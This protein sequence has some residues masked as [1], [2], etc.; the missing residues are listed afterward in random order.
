MRHK[1]KRL[2]RRQRERRRRCAAGQTA[3]GT[4]MDDLTVPRVN[5]RHNAILREAQR[6]V[7]AGLS[8]IP[9][10]TDGSKAPAIEW[11]AYQTQR[12]TPDELRTWFTAGRYGIGILGG[13]ISGH[14]EIADFDLADLFPPWCDL[15]E[16]LAPGLLIRLPVVQTP[17][18]GYHVYYR[19]ES[20]AGNQK[21][22]QRLG[23]D[24]QPKTLVETRGR[25]GY[26]LAPGSPPTCHL[27]HKLYVV[28][29]GHLD[30]IPV[31][32]PDERRILLDAARSF[33]AYVPPEQVYHAPASG[34]RPQGPGDRPGDVFA[35]HATWEEVLL[36]HGWVKVGQRGDVGLW[37]RPGKHG[38]GCSA[39]TNIGGSGLLYVFSSN[40]FPFE[41]QTAYSLFAAY[42]WLEHHGDFQAA[43][44]ALADRGYGER[45]TAH[46]VE[47]LSPAGA[48]NGGAPYRGY[49]GYQ[50]YRG[51]GREVSHG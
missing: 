21:L 37:L 32:T 44:K 41:P 35:R 11:K 10:K 1:R 5:H 6:L 30:D 49:Q 33:N 47:P 50:P 45:H 34:P 13:A 27:R 14:L 17:S 25:G 7:A 28:I 15:V 29:D 4:Y 38:R 51:Y 22:A 40:A 3:Q 20:I 18:G 43:A 9:I 2:P 46:E 48:P 16:E 8:L 23:A 26:V 12:A 36:P 39:T 19:C 42:A 31:I 24:G